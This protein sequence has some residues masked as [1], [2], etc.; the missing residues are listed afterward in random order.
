MALSAR[1]KPS[2]HI[3]PTRITPDVSE[4]KLKYLLKYNSNGEWMASSAPCRKKMEMWKK[5]IKYANPNRPVGAFFINSQYLSGCIHE[6]SWTDEP[7][8]HTT[9][10]VIVFVSNFGLS[11]TRINLFRESCAEC[12]GTVQSN[13]YRCIIILIF[14]D[15]GVVPLHLPYIFF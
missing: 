13:I 2:V 8:T 6:Y 5:T 11:R 15:L 3:P 7:D 14:L 4:K 12:S 9:L 10:T 1:G